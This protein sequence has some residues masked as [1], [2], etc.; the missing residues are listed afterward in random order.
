MSDVEVHIDLDRQTRRVGLLHRQP[1]RRSETVTFDY[2]EAWLKDERRFSIEPALRLTRGAFAPVQG[3]TLFGS[4]GD[5][6]PDTWGR[7]LMQRAE[8]KRAAREHRAV[9]TLS[10]TDYL[11]GVTD[12]TRLGAL[13]FRPV[14]EAV[15]QAPAPA[16]VPALVELGRL[17]H[18]T[19]RILKDEET[20]EDLELIFAP[21][22]SP[23]RR[24][25]E[26]FRHRRARASVDGEVSQG[27]Q[28]PTAS[29]PGKRSPC[30]LLT[31]RE[32]V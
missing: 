3:Q 2:D 24:V 31:G 30:V 17:L 8:R 9:R 21:G 16:G 18:I 14:G 19:G 11:L 12:E 32:I 20:D 10:E 22:S 13:R 4:I 15:F 1:G 29:K 5:S 7:R 25:S 6:A 23:G 27:N 26:V 28:L